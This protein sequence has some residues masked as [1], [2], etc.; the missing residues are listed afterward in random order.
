MDKRLGVNSEMGQK[1]I[2]DSLRAVDLHPQCGDNCQGHNYRHE[3]R[4]FKI[5]LAVGSLVD[6]QRQ[7][8]GSAALQGYNNDYKFYSIEK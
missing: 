3:K 7:Q 8:K 2:Q 4:D 5:F 6:G 1:C